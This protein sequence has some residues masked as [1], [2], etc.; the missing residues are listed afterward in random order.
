MPKTTRKPGPVTVNADRWGIGED[1]EPSIRLIPRSGSDPDRRDEINQDLSDRINEASAQL[2]LWERQLMRLRG[3]TSYADQMLAMSLTVQHADLIGKVY[4]MEEDLFTGLIAALQEASANAPEYPGLYD[5]TP[6][7]K[8]MLYGERSKLT[9]EPPKQPDLYQD[10]HHPK[11]I[12]WLD[13][14][15]DI[16]YGDEY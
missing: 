4:Q 5:D 12:E 14:I 6:E 3:S 9:Y 8:D 1:G 16:E 11:H 10:V 13:Q 15:D 7:Q 2:L